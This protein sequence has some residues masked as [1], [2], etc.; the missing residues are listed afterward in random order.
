MATRPLKRIAISNN[1]FDVQYFNL[2]LA[3]FHDGG[4]RNFTVAAALPAI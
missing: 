4:L 2:K 1:C 3:Q